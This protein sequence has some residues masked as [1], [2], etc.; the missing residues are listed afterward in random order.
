MAGSVPVR[1]DSGRIRRNPRSCWTS[2]AVDTDVHPGGAPRSLFFL[3][4]FRRRDRYRP[5]SV[6]GELRGELI[7][8]GLKG[9]LAAVGV[10]EATPFDSVRD[11][12]LERRGLGLNGEMQFTYRN[13]QRSTDPS[14]TLPGARS[15]IV[16]AYRYDTNVVDSDEV[17]AEVVAS[18]NRSVTYGRVARYATDDHYDRLRGLLRSLSAHLKAEGYKAVVVCD[19][20]AMVDRAAAVRAGL[21]FYGKSANVLLPGQGSW[22]VLGSVITDAELEPTGGQVPDGCGT[23]TRCLDGCPTWAIIAPGVVDARRCL[24]WL[25]QAPGDFPR[26][27]RG[28]L[29]DRIY[30]CDEC[31][32]VCPPSRRADRL[33]IGRSPRGAEPAAPRH[34]PHG[35]VD[36]EWMLSASDTELMAE[37]G[38]WYIPGRDPVYLRRNALVVYGNR[39]VPTTEGEAESVLGPHLDGE[40]EMIAAHAAWAALNLGHP[41]LV[42]SRLSRPAIAD[43]L[44]EFGIQVETFHR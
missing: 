21:G 14:R 30:G 13:P 3:R 10:C 42:T 32:E 23:C 37:L 33:D 35:W 18:V 31:Q 28:A 29:G 38:R 4:L 6:N 20:N 39:T 5:V 15:M 7:E 17:G 44:A 9:G 22:F 40:N 8:M 1:A 43:E 41:G 12:L 2:P 27:F 24:S 16:A 19:D 11:V 34:S 36:V 25:I 26:E